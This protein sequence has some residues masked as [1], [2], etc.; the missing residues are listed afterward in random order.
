[1]TE[2]IVVGG[3]IVGA[4][5]TYHLATAEVDVLLVDRAHEGRATAAGAGIVSPVTSTS[6]DDAWYDL[7]ADAAEYYPDLDDELRDAGVAETGYAATAVMVVAADRDERAT[8]D[9]ARERILDRRRRRGN[10]PADQLYELAP[11]EAAERFPPLGDVH[12]ALYYEGGARVDGRTFAAALRTAATTAGATDRT[13]TVERLRIDDGRVVGAVVDGDTITADRVV[14]AG[15]AWSPAFGAQLGVSIPVAPHR[16]Q[17]AHLDVSGET[18]SWPIVTAFHGHYL[19]PWPDGRVATGATRE[20]GVGYDPTMT[21]AGVREVLSEAMRV[22]PGLDEAGIRDLRV[23]LRPA[24][25][26]ELPVLGPV[27]TVDGVHLA[28]G[29]GPTGL[30]IGPYT[31]KLVAQS[32]REETPDRSISPYGLDRFD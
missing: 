27:P 30:T 8:F 31:G 5:V 17:I 1:M 16:G 18:G 23:G 21:V 13:G 26:D 25:T 22:A 4:S 7:A 2:V 29:H 19:V 11:K 6:H 20:A 28:T 24:T 32:V 9:A 10:P 15:G 12:R 3:G 14:I